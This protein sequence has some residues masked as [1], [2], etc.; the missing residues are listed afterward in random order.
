MPLPS[1]VLQA[2]LVEALFEPSVEQRDAD[3]TGAGV[4]DAGVARFPE[5]GYAAGDNR[6][7]LIRS[8]FSIA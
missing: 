3:E 7:T 2:E 8:A 1:P 4:V 5:S 6:S